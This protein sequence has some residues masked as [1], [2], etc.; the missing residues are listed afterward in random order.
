MTGPMTDRH[1]TELAAGI[2][3]ATAIA[4]GL[5]TSAVDTARLEQAWKA[6]LEHMCLVRF[7]DRSWQL[8]LQSD[9]WKSFVSLY[10][11]S[12]FHVARKNFFTGA[13]I[14]SGLIT[15]DISLLEMSG[16]ASFQGNPTFFNLSK[17][18]L[19]FVVLGA[20]NMLILKQYV[21]QQLVSGR[22][23]FTY[24][25]PLNPD[26]ELCRAAL[27]EAAVLVRPRPRGTRLQRDEAIY[28]LAP[29]SEEDT[30]SMPAGEQGLHAMSAE[31]AGLLGALAALGLG[32][33]IMAALKGLGT[34]LLV[35][36]RALISFI[37]VIII[38]PE[39]TQAGLPATSARR[40]NRG[41]VLTY[42]I[43]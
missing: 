15:S 6:H 12:L 9:G 32:A 24:R 33:E 39:E 13:L 42:H 40:I 14:T 25:S 38:V 18:R 30:I 17:A 1:K 5:H 16:M 3:G 4:W 11:P 21:E 22:P 8:F 34:G 23:F 37:P 7:S 27:S 2:V 35:S 26:S 20:A 31:Q 41:Q 43:I 36:A 28:P 10:R 19:P 29:L